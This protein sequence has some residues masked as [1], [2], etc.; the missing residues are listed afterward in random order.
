MKTKLF[1]SLLLTASLLLLT[2][3]QLFT[4]V[5]ESTPPKATVSPQT[6]SDTEPETTE[7]KDVTT[8]PETEPLTE[9]ATEAEPTNVES[10]EDSTVPS[11]ENYLGYWSSPYEHGEITIIEI[12]DDWLIFEAA[13]YRQFGVKAKAFKED[14]RYVFSKNDDSYISGLNVSGCV[15]LLE[16][17]VALT[18]F[19]LPSTWEGLNKRFEYCVQT[20]LQYPE[21]DATDTES[22]ETTPSEVE[23]VEINLGAA[24][25][26]ELTPVVTKDLIPSQDYLGTWGIYSDHPLRIES[27]TDETIKFSD[28]VFRYFG[29]SAT[30]VLV[31][32]E[33]VFGPDVSPEPCSPEGCSGKLEF[34]NGN[35]LV[36]YDSFG[37]AWESDNYVQGQKGTYRVTKNYDY[38]PE[39]GRTYHADIFPCGTNYGATPIIG[40]GDIVFSTFESGYS[41]V[42]WEIYNC[43][44]SCESL[45]DC[46]VAKFLLPSYPSATYEYKLYAEYSPDDGW[47]YPTKLYLSQNKDGTIED[48][49]EI[50]NDRHFMYVIELSDDL[51]LTLGICPTMLTGYFLGEDPGG[52]TLEELEMINSCVKTI[53]V[54]YI[55]DT[56]LDTESEDGPVITG[57][58]KGGDEA[59]IKVGDDVVRD[60]TVTFSKWY[61]GYY[62]VLAEI[63]L[64]DEECTCTAYD[65]F[66]SILS[67]PELVKSSEYDTDDGFP[68]PT[69]RY[70]RNTEDFTDEAYIA[71][72]KRHYYYDVKLADGIH[73]VIYIDP[74]D[75]TSEIPEN[76]VEMIEEVVKSAVATITVPKAE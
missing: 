30:A 54:S 36:T 68:Y 13:V 33:W 26:V 50:S 25:D 70:E 6:T 57:K 38:V 29:I 59:Y 39:G 42:D 52:A 35:V 63:V 44:D 46:S 74:I 75:A 17:G 31:D 10:F 41:V 14:G 22:A 72:V 8:E 11:I 43:G 2:S 48:P 51:T 76:E 66:N 3:C 67:L 1:I 64:C 40:E 5:P 12:S 56:K 23:T 24:G 9:E 18:Y 61:D 49:N 19:D 69:I 62:P 15:E 27:I 65:L 7:T 55:L 53:S 37:E 4:D 58:I 45:G 71:K 20:M 28:S 73:L 32:G 34:I 47:T 60:S 16:D 21:S